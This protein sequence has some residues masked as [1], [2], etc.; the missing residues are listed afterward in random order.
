MDRPTIRSIKT[1]MTTRLHLHSTTIHQNS[2][3]D[4]SSE[5]G[6]V[7]I[8]VLMDRRTMEM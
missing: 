2:D 6:R 4:G 8:R 5:Y 1:L 7:V 3:F